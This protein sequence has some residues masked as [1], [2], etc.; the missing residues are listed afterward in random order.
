MLLIAALI[1]IHRSQSLTSSTKIVWVL[2]A[3]GFPF[4]GSVAWF[5]FGRSSAPS[6]NEPIGSSR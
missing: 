3:L 2:A 4:L 1:D 6:G 5:L